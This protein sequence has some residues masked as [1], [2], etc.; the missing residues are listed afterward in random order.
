M[1][2]SVTFVTKPTLFLFGAVWE[3]TLSPILNV[4]VVSG[5]NISLSSLIVSRASAIFLLIIS[6]R[7]RVVAVLISEML[8]LLVCSVDDFSVVCVQVS[9]DVGCFLSSVKCL[10]SVQ[11]LVVPCQGVRR[12]FLWV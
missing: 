3:N 8:I 2:A 7:V 1:N 5:S 9:S 10:I 11:T 4:L 12:G 6:K